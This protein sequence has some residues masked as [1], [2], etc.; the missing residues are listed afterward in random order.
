MVKLKG[1]LI[2]NRIICENN[3]YARDLYI[4]KGYGVM[5]NNNIELSLIEALYLLKKGIIEIYDYRNNIVDEKKI[6]KIGKRNISNFWIK[7]IV[8][9]DLRDRGYVVKTAFKFGADFRVYE[10]GKKVGEEHSKWIVFTSYEHDKVTWQDIAA[11]NRV[12][13]STRKRLLLAVVDDESNVTYYE[14]KWI[15]P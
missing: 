2:K 9:S 5:V 13:H 7:F 15:R 3:D 4:N 1:L 12:A 6:L 8:Y 11:K 14:L 10:K